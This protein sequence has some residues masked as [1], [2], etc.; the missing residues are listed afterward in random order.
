VAADVVDD[1][2]DFRPWLDRPPL[3]VRRVI[4]PLLLRDV[5]VLSDDDEMEGLVEEVSV[6]V[7]VVF[8]V[9]GIGV[10]GAMACS[11]DRDVDVGGGVAWSA[12]DGVPKSFDAVEFVVGES[13]MS[14][15]EKASRKFEGPRGVASPV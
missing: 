15:C 9:V 13:V 11:L 5:V 2:D 7:V 6:V 14:L 3:L 8:V 4:P 10:V 1:D 12:P